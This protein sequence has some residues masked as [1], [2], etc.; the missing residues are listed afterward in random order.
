MGGMVDPSARSD[1]A[2]IDRCPTCGGD[3]F[4]YIADDVVQCENCTYLWIRPPDDDGEGD[5]A[6]GEG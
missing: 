6:G 1:D 3:R 4:R 5:R 2:R